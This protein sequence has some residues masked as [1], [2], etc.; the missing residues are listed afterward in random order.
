VPEDSDDS[1]R[2]TNDDVM[3][4]IEESEKRLLEQRVVFEAD[5]RSLVAAANEKLHDQRTFFEEALWKQRASF[6]ANLQSVQKASFENVVSDGFATLSAQLLPLRELAPTREGP[7]RVVA[8]QIE[9]ERLA[10]ERPL[11]R[12]TDFDVDPRE[13]PNVPKQPQAF[14]QQGRTP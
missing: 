8:A 6:E 7:S 4:L 10:L 14:Q 12:G 3:R 11:W 1:K 2:N 5:M 9:A 13:Q